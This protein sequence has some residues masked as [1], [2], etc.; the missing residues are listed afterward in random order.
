MTE[1]I[2]RHGQRYRPQELVRRATGREITAE[3]FVEYVTE[4]FG[5]LYDL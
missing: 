5:S 4:K 3:P 1:S 2:H